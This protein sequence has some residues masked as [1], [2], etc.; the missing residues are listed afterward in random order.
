G[1]GIHPRHLR[2]RLSDAPPQSSMALWNPSRVYRNI[3]QLRV[4]HFNNAIEGCSTL[5]VRFFYP[6]QRLE[7]TARV[8]RNERLRI[9][10]ALNHRGPKPEHHPV[11]P[12][13]QI[14]G[15]DEI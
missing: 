12:V 5:S 7:N 8:E 1:Q 4:N 14:D 10:V 9:E 6:Q 13:I 2:S 11:L 15:V 3:K